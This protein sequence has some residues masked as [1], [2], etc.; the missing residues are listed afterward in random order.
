MMM[1]DPPFEPDPSLVARWR[2]AGG[3]QPVESEAAGPAA[4]GPD[5]LTLAAYADGRLDAAEAERVEAALAADPELLD[6]LLALRLPPATETPSAALI[7][8]AQA[9]VSAA[10]AAADPVVVPF[11]RRPAREAPP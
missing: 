2:A 5:A 8:S 1:D 3:V 10:S 4:T 7:R 6:T 9:L 11:G